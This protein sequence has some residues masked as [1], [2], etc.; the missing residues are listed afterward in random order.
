MYFD[1]HAQQCLGRSG[2]LW[3]CCGVFVGCS[4][5]SSFGTWEAKMTFQRLAIRQ[6]CSRALIPAINPQV[7]I[8]LFVL[9]LTGVKFLSVFDSNLGDISYDMSVWSEPHFDLPD[10]GRQLQQC[11]SRTATPF[12]TAIALATVPTSSAVTIADT[13]ISRVINHGNP[14]EIAAAPRFTSCRATGTIQEAA[15]NKQ[16]EAT[17]SG[18]LEIPNTSSV[19][20]QAQDDQTLSSRNSKHGQTEKHFC[21]YSDYGRSR[22]GSK[23]LSQRSLGSASSWST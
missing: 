2:L 19:H 5:K 10:L 14:S 22:P 1:L 3:W 11:V 9:L 18:A 16:L 21:T 12:G 4:M 20:R 6:A 15:E 23:L 8:P 17:T 7:I 13:I